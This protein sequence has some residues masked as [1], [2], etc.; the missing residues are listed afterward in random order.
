MEG[1]WR[2]AAGLDPKPEDY[3]GVD[4]WSTPER[5]GWLTKQ[6]EYIKTWRRRLLR[7]PR[8]QAT[9]RHPGGYLPHRQGRRGRP[10][11]AVCLRALHQPRH[12][13][14]HRR[15]REGEGG[16]DKLHR[17]LHS[18]AFEIRHGFRSRRL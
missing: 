16:M 12:H 17:T 3:E 15:L 8:F 14:L 6:G 9:W 1:L 5:A 2:A 11:Q 18:P 13:V 7:H 4:F 10:Q